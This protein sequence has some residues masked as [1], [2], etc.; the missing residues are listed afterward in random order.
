MPHLHF[1][2]EIS[3]Y[4]KKIENKAP[5]PMQC[6]VFKQPWRNDYFAIDPGCKNGC[7]FCIFS[8]GE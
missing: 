3:K 7:T 1:I 8:A 5:E 2:S 4:E 6:N